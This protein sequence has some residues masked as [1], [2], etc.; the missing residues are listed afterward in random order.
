MEYLEIK[1]TVRINPLYPCAVKSIADELSVFRFS[2]DNGFILVNLWAF[3]LGIEGEGQ[4]SCPKPICTLVDKLNNYLDDQS[5]IEIYRDT[6]L[7]TLQ[8]NFL[9]DNHR[10]IAHQERDLLVQSA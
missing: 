4:I 7:Q 6:D 2:G 5:T 3:A 8:I 10:V 1:G 9:H